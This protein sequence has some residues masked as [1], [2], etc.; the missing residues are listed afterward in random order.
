MESD[1]ETTPDRAA[2]DAHKPGDEELVAAVRRGDRDALTVLYDRH[3][4]HVYTIAKRVLRSGAD[5]EPIV[6]DVFF[7]LWRSPESFDPSRSSC[8]TYLIVMARSRAIDRL[9]SLRLHQGHT[10]AAAEEA[11]ITRTDSDSPE[12]QAASKDDR[13]VVHEAVDALS[14]E[15]GNAIR[16]AF[17]DGKTHDEIASELD[18]PLGTIKSRIRAGLRILQSKLALLRRPDDAP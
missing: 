7:E 15:Q 18:E 14:D 9:R 3:A 8:R 13:R 1:P 4:A 12:E 16:M 10:R 17:F 11:A 2:A 6:S 5:A